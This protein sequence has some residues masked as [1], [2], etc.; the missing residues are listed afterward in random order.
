MLLNNAMVPE[1]LPVLRANDFY[2]PNHGSVYSAIVDMFTAGEPADPVTVGAELERRGEFTKVGGAKALMDFISIVPTAL[3]ASYYAKCVADKARLRRLADVGSKLVHIAYTEG[4]DADEV[5]AQ[6]ETFFREVNTPVEGG[7]LMR[8]LVTQWREHV[9]DASDII[10]TPWHELN[11]YLSGGLRRGKLYVVGGR[12]GGG[13]SMCGLNISGFVAENDLP[14]TIFSLEMGNIEVTSRL[15]A[16]GAWAN[17]GQIFSKRMDKD[18]YYRVDEY[19]ESHPSFLSRLEV[20]DRASIT[21]EEIVAHLRVRKP[22]CCFV[23]YCQLISPSD[24]RAARR[25]QIDHITRSLKVAAQ[26]VGCAIVLA[27]QLNRGPTSGA[28]RAPVISDLRESGGIENDADVVLLLYREENNEGFVQMNIG[29]NRDGKQGHL[30][31]A[32][33]GDVARIGDG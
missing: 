30:Q 15:L 6:A 19:L 26:D 18:T 31:F 20:V 9:D 7:V 32:F 24:G 5:V 1:V 25:E 23:D 17:Y 11:N 13:K 29:K 14:V 10:P 16:W 2:R 22:A 12:P 8:D 3:N 27:S 4:S 33:R 28:G 21:V